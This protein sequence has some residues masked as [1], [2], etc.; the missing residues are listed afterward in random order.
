MKP[1]NPLYYRWKGK[2]LH[3][4]IHILS[5]M[6]LL[7]RW[8]FFSVFTG[9]IMGLIGVAFVYCIQSVTTLRTNFV[10]M[11]LTLPLGGLLIV[12][13][14]RISHDQND[15][16]TNMVLASLRSEAELPV[17]MA[18]MIFISTIITHLCGGSA[19]REGAALQLG[20]SVGNLL[21]RLFR[22]N[23]R[24]IRVMILCGMSAAFSAIFRTP[25]AA[26]VFAM[27]VGCVG[28]MQYAALVPCTISS[29]TASYLASKL[30][31]P[32]AH[33]SVTKVPGLHPL[34]AL[35]ILLLGILCAAVSI[36]FCILLHQCEKRLKQKFPN[37]YL[38]ILAASGILLLLLLLLRSRDYLGVGTNVISS[39]IAGKVVW[40]AFLAKMLF[41]A[42][43]LGGGFKGGEIVPS[44]FIGATFGCLF[45]QL[46]H[47]SPSFC[48]SVGMIALFCGVTNCPL[49]SL[50]I[51]IE[52]FGAQGTP[53]YSLAIAVSYLLSGYYGLYR[54]QKF[55][56]SK[57]AEKPASHKTRRS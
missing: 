21:G 27:E 14:Y 36:L 31:I 32:L 15:K 40:Y 37:P 34:P 2:L 30:G 19:G 4:G 50:L 54:E 11:P 52:L 18:P 22:L 41:T 12:W 9:S 57:F 3:S 42:V 46:L 17:Q 26:A 45:G 43:T 24:D 20:G 49:A 28:A 7:I 33:F 55:L 44:F 13:L 29:L 35:K 23:K 51:A 39:A 38:R 8:T 1:H 56:Y 25:I 16:G 10:W 48:A 5:H 47:L 6:R 53:Y